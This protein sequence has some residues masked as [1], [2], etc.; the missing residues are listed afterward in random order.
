MGVCA[1]EDGIGKVF[2]I[3][4]RFDQV[5]SGVELYDPS[6]G[7]WSARADLPT[8][9]AG[10]GAVWVPSTNTIY[11]IG[12]RDCP[13]PHCGTSLATNEA[14][15]V[16]AGTWSAQAPMPTPM[17]DSYSTVYSA[18]TGKIYVFGGFDG[19]SV[20]GLVQIYDP[21]ADT[22]STGA[23]VPTPRSN[24]IAGVCGG[25]IYAIGGFDGSANLDTNE[26]YDPV[27]DAWSAPQ[28]AKPTPASEIAASA[29]S[30]GSDIF[31]IGSGIFGLAGG[32]NEVFTCEEVTA[33]CT[34]DTPGAILG[35]SGN[36]VLTGTPDDDCIIG[37]DGVDVLL[38]GDG[39]D[40]INGG[41]GSDVIDGGLGDDKIKGGEGDDTIDGNEGT[42]T[43]D[44]GRDI[45]VCL[46]GEAVK[47]CEG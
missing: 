28:S 40:K 11:V 45:D 41:E 22:W 44:G 24:L 12:G 47:N 43:L 6:S 29:I 16:A 39:K 4:G 34:I 23:P 42:D 8:P 10:L 32:V 9:R 3:G 21:A 20:T 38:G 14:Y 31:A 25:L 35:T 26:A 37:L 7:T 33:A 30:T 36:D 5:L 46:N 19:D 1:E 27:A 2:V 17:M 18:A 13:S 15:D